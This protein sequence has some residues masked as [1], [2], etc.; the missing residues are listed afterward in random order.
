MNR[1]LIILCLSACC[2][3]AWSDAIDSAA[4][5]VDLNSWSAATSGAVNQATSLPNLPEPALPDASLLPTQS[6]SLL[7][8]GS[9]NGDRIIVKQNFASAKGAPI[10]L[11]V[12]S[13]KIPDTT[14]GWL[15]SSTPLKTEAVVNLGWRLG[16]NQQILFSTAQLRGMV[17]TEQDGKAGGNLNQYTSGLNYRYFVN[18]Q[19][20]TGLEWSGYVSESPGLNP[21]VDSQQHNA[22]NN[23][24]GMRLGVEASPLPD[25]KLKI[26]IGGERFSSDALSGAEAV[27]SLN[28]SIKWSQILLPTVKYNAGLEDN[29]VQRSIST[30]LDFNL[31]NGQQLGLKL[32]HTQWSAGQNPDYLVQLSYSLQFGKKFMPFQTKAGN[33]WNAGLVTEVLQRPSYLPKSVL[34]KPESNIN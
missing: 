10:D 27:Q 19:W 25:S 9:F 12:V 8:K 15:M 4:S 34:S 23:L 1:I 32:A 33:A 29:G 5:A 26:G 14:L 31:R 11:D 18:R 7:L 24:I 21:A 3:I 20:L 22:A 28:T 6:G 2:P 30:G 16:G 17:S 13:Q